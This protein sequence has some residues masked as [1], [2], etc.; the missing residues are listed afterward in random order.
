LCLAAVSS[1]AQV[2][3]AWVNRYNGG[4]TN[5]SHSPIGIAMDGSGNVFVAGSSQ[6]SAT[7]S[8]YVVLKYAPDGTQVWA[9]R[10]APPAG[11]GTAAS[12]ALDN[13]GDTT[14]TGSAGTA[15]IS[16]AGALAWV[17]PYAA[18]SLA[19]DANG[20]IYVTG[21]STNSSG[22]PWGNA[23]AF[24]VARLDAA[25]GSNVWTVGWTT[26]PGYPSGADVV[27]VDRG[28]NLFVGAWA[29]D[30]VQWPVPVYTQ[31]LVGFDALGDPAWA[32]H[33][34][35]FDEDAGAGYVERILFDSAG[36]AYVIGRSEA[37]DVIGKV[38]PTGTLVWWARDDDV[39]P[40]SGAAVDAAGNLYRTGSYPY[41]FCIDKLDG[42]TGAVLWRTMVSWVDP[43]YYTS[44]GIALDLAGNA[45][46][47]GS[48]AST[49]G[50]G[51]D[52][53]TVKFDSN[54]NL[55]WSKL[56]NGSAGGATAIAVA[57]DGSIYVTG[58]S[59]NT[60]G[61]TDITTIKYVQ[62][63][64][65]QPGPGGAMLLELPGLPGSSAGL[66]ATTNLVNW[67]ELGPVVAGTNGLFQFMDTNAPLY[68]WRFYRW[69]SP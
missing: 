54:G 62:D 43:A 46:V 11:G 36:D 10:W 58:Y 41:N 60:S 6:S 33:F 56:Y 1:S 20:T 9:A 38:S 37:S 28:G 63:P 49:S 66:A 29:R 44:T 5:L 17:A 59:A 34:D 67:T 52:W 31:F 30:Y 15:K 55:R 12:F 22:A 3:E 35:P 65:I 53:A 18:T 69:H 32:C 47:C 2:H 8:D 13:H 64:T 42:G 48:H 39:V 19:A 27:A 4:Y 14:L 45:Y 25:T 24:A 26:Y 51:Y 57:A 61:G 21:F 40:T 68:P 16:A 23:F 7:N 50:S